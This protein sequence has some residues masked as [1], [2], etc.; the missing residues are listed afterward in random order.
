M[1]SRKGRLFL[2]IFTLNS[3]G[4][5]DWLISSLVRLITLS[6]YGGGVKHFLLP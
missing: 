1:G 6:L 5:P 4:L 3:G 2:L